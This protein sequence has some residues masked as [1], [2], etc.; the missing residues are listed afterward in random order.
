MAVI[1][2]F[3][4]MIVLKESLDINELRQSRWEWREKKLTKN[5][6]KLLV[7]FFRIGLIVMTSVIFA[8]SSCAQRVVI[9]WGRCGPFRSSQ[10]HLWFHPLCGQDL[11][12]SPAGGSIF[13]LHFVLL[14]LTYAQKLSASTLTV[15]TR[16]APPAVKTDCCQL[17]IS[18]LFSRCLCLLST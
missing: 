17:E 4:A 15:F 8:I 11:C 10:D 16:M 7:N 14:R 18:S 13:L 1:F 2:I 6:K 5:E 3:K 12:C 9:C